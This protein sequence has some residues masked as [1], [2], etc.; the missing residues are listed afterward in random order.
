MRRTCNAKVVSSILTNGYPNNSF[1]QIYETMFYNILYNNFYPPFY[2]NLIDTY[3]NIYLSHSEGIYFY[4]NKLI[5]Y[6]FA[7]II[8]EFSFFYFITNHS[9]IKFI[10]KLLMN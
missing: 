2:L 5:F 1:Y 9:K 8:Y 6:Q 7:E 4:L 10:F 3:N